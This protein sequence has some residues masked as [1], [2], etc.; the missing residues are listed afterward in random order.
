MLPQTGRLW[1]PTR[2]S[3]SLDGSCCGRPRRVND[4]QPQLAPP[5]QPLRGLQRHDGRRPD[6]R[7]LRQE[8]VRRAVCRRPGQGRRCARDHRE[9]AR[10]GDRSRQ[11][12]EELRPRRRSWTG[13][14]GPQRWIHRRQSTSW[15]RRSRGPGCEDQLLSETLDETARTARSS[16]PPRR[17]R[18]SPA[19]GRPRARDVIGMHFNPAPIM[20]LVEVV[21]LLD[22]RVTKTMRA[23]AAKVGKVAVADAACSSSMVP[24]RSPPPQRRGEDAAGP[25]ARYRRRHRHRDP[26]RAVCCRWGL[27][28]LPDVV[29]ND[30]RRRSS[31]APPSS[32]ASGFA[33]A[34]LLGHGH[35][36]DLGRKTQRGF[37][38]DTREALPVRSAPRTPQL[39]SSAWTDRPG[40]GAGD[41]D[42]LDHRLVY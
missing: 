41:L 5:D 9:V 19:R 28:S 27:F 39:T 31:A 23:A 24:C 34:P 16:P 13:S 38:D 30:V 21:Q 40:A 29:G 2:M 10:Q 20:K 25:D 1:V 26:S 15:W 6:R 22:E 17:R 35:R 36:G 3:S 37:W 7:G 33:P 42:L 32:S 4:D 11:A 8:R 18:S 12:L 14:P